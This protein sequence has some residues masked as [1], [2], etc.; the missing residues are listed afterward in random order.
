MVGGFYHCSVGKGIRY[1]KVLRLNDLRSSIITFQKADP[2]NTQTQAFFIDQRYYK[3]YHPPL[4]AYAQRDRRDNRGNN[5]ARIGKKKCFVCNKKGCWSNNHTKKKCEESKKKFK[6]RFSQRFDKRASQY[7][8]EYKRVDY[9]IDDEIEDIDEAAEALMI[10]FRFP[11]PSNIDQA[12]V[13][14]NTFI[15]SFGTIH[16]AETMIVYLANCYFNHAITRADPTLTPHES[17]PFTYITS[18]DILRTNFM[19]SSLIQELRNDQQPDTGSFL[20]T[21]RR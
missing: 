13:N 21:K 19:V 5:Q 6:E 9:E 11:S 12:N 15:T 16:Q 3:Q 8:A 17:D 1:S 2:D 10:D 7:I 4:S 18:K 14:T 20:H